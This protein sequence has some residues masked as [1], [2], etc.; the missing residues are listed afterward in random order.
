MTDKLHAF[1]YENVYKNP[2]AK[3]EEGKAEA[4][5]EM[6]FRYF[7]R[8]PKSFRPSTAVLSA[9]SRWEGRSAIIF[10]V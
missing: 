9:R 8:I 7:E 5:L 6:L 1:L 2:I 4:M 10:P 3:G